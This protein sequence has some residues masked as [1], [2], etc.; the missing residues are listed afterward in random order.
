MAQNHPGVFDPEFSSKGQF[1]DEISSGAQMSEEFE[2]N[3]KKLQP[4]RVY[5]IT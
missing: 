1:S 5:V 4:R 3:G 2:T